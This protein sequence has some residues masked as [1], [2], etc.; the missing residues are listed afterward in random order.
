[1]YQAGYIFYLIGSEGFSEEEKPN[2]HLRLHAFA[3]FAG[4]LATLLQ[5][6]RYSSY[7]ERTIR[8]YL[9]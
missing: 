7:N 9:P 4:T 2:D 3:T 5:P 6:G 8:E 1:M